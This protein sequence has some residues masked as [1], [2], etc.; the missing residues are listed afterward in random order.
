V[1]IYE[2]KLTAQKENLTS[3]EN[4]QHQNHNA[5]DHPVGQEFAE[6]GD[7]AAGCKLLQP[8]QQQRR[9]QGPQPDIPPSGADGGQHFE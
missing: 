9:Y 5:A 6:D 2:G 1:R 4:P 3:H 8:D 7:N